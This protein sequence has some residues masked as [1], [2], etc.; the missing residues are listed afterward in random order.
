MIAARAMG[1]DGT[2]RQEPSVYAES[3]VADVLGG[4]NYPIWRGGYAS[5]VKFTSSWF[6]ASVS[7]CFGYELPVR[8]VG[9]HG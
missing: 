9:G 5:I 4:V 2:P 8:Y 1:E 3:V 7:V 6:P